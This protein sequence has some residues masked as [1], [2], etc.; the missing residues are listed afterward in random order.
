LEAYVREGKSILVRL[1]FILFL[2]NH[3]VLAF[4]HKLKIIY[5][6]NMP[7]IEQVNNTGGLPQLATLLEISRREN[8]DTIFIHGGDSLGPSLLSSFDRG[9][10]MIDLLNSLQVDAMAVAKR[11]FSYYEDELTLRTSEAEFPI[12]SANVF[13]PL[14]NGNLS[15]LLPG[16]LIE[17][18]GYTIGVTSIV[19]EQLIVSYLPK[20]ISLLDSET[21][22]KKAA[23][24]LREQGAD[25]I[26]LLSD[27]E[28]EQTKSW[29]NNEIID[30]AIISSRNDNKY[31]YN[32]DHRTVTSKGIEYGKALELDIVLQNNSN[33]KL[34]YTTDGRAVDLSNFPA[35]NFI[36]RKITQHLSIL[37]TL[38][39]KEIG[40]FGTEVH[41][42]KTLVRSK[43]NAFGNLVTD[44]LKAS[45]N[46]DIAIINSGSIRG[47][48]TYPKGQKIT[49]KIIKQELPFRNKGTVIEITGSQLI[50][51]LEN[52]FSL[53]SE[54]GGQYP[55]VSGMQVLY[56]SSAE[57]GKRVVSVYINGSPLIKDKSYRL[58]TTEFLVKGGSGYEVFKNA[59]RLQKNVSAQ[60]I[61]DIVT[62]YITKQQLVSPKIEGRIRELNDSK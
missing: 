24:S 16:I 12:I 26:L 10:H 53:I 52:G 49:L 41:T 55:Q 11:E 18:D 20:R 31:L 3:S 14:T 22:V 36:E 28:T 61:A 30:L 48:R 21:S 17:R 51:A 19:S 42:L 54:V 37:S 59:K 8:P 27:Y 47:D 38:L 6:S 25:F 39:S 15:G 50:Q 23:H 57:V 32:V 46:T 43:E 44:A 4:E 33:G 1:C 35:D 40:T 58:A 60:T 5:V 56:S 29:I 45:L 62:D 7:E 13:D 9:A 34:D 2:C